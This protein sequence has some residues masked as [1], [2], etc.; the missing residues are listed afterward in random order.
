MATIDFMSTAPRPQLAV[1]DLPGERRVPPALGLGR[2]HVD[3]A[4]EQ[5]RASAPSPPA[6]RATRLAR[7]GAGDSTSGST[8]AA[9]RVSARKATASASLPGGL[10]VSNR[11]SAASSS[12]TAAPS[13]SQST[14]SSAGCIRPPV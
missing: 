12:T 14:C 8:P 5:Q 13:R 3:V 10:V 6:S 7:P 9:A 2:D 4:V 1:V 11:S